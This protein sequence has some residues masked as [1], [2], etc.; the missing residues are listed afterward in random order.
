[1]VIKRITNMKKS[2]K[3]MPAFLKGKDK[4]TKTKDGCCPTC[5]KKK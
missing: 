1:L 3:K 4:E 5:G 2:T